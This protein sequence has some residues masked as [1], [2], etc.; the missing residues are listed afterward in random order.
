ML[1][2]LGVVIVVLSLGKE[3]VP[4]RGS[5]RS[6]GHRS[7]D[8]TAMAMVMAGSVIIVMMLATMSMNM[9]VSMTPLFADDENL[10]VGD[11]AADDGD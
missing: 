1:L 6:K 10:D 8:V 9:R 3:M 5:A 7:M 11:G 2:L 4:R